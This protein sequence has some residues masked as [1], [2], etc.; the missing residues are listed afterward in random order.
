MRSVSLLDP[1][2]GGI[3]R[4]ADGRLRLVTA[5]ELE[6]HGTSLQDRDLAERIAAA[7]AGAEIRGILFRMIDDAVARD[8]RAASWAARAG[9]HRGYAMY[10]LA[11]HLARVALAASTIGPTFE[12]GLARLHAGAVTFLLAQPAARIFFDARDREPFALL[13]RLEVS[14]ALLATYGRFV[15]EGRRGDATVTIEGE[16][17]WI[18]HAWVPMIRSVFPALGRPPGEVDCEL[19]GRFAG[20][21]RVRW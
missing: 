20:R 21:V 12:L 4:R 6:S 10:P 18:E 14:R 9:R 11:E 17:L 13:R 1:R 3:D 5:P 2:D 19:D 15:V 7:P 8:P 16:P